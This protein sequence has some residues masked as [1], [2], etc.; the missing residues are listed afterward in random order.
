MW[1]A[2]FWSI[3]KTQQT[4]EI[5]PES[6]PVSWPKNGPSFVRNLAS[7]ERGR[8]IAAAVISLGQSLNMKVI[9]EGVETVNRR[10]GYADQN[11]RVS[12]SCPGIRC[13]TVLALTLRF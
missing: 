13:Q 9:A 11:V 3:S 4:S 1:T 2:P 6:L 7:D 10:D 8:S 12:V 5:A